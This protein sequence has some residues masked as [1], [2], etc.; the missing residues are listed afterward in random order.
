ME[1][2]TVTTILINGEDRT[3]QIKAWRLSLN[4][5]TNEIELIW[6]RQR[7]PGISAVLNPPK[8]CLVNFCLKR[9]IPTFSL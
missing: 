1:G 7:T 2:K 6:D 8:T 4:K 5:A 9:A 3:R